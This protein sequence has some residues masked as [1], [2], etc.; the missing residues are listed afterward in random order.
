[1]HI[2]SF[3]LR[4]GIRRYAFHASKLYTTKKIPEKTWI[5]GNTGTLQYTSETKF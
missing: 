2:R 3:L 1:M 5:L 4:Q